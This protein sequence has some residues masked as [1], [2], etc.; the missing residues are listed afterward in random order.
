MITTEILRQNK[1]FDWSDIALRYDKP[2]LLLGNGFSLQFSENFSYNSLFNLFLENCDDTHKDLFSHFGTVNFEQI[3]RYLTYAKKVNELLALPSQPIDIALQNLKTGLIKTIETVHPRVENINFEQ[4]K[5]VAKQL[6]NFGDIFT[7][8]YDLF[9]YHI[10]MQSKDISREEKEYIAYQDY[11]WG[12]DCPL[13]FKQFMSTQGYVYKHLYYLHGS[14][15]IF[16]NKLEI[17]K[18]N[19]DN[20]ETELIDLISTQIQDNNFPIFI[21]EGT[22]LEKQM[23]INE[24]R[25]LTFCSDKLKVSSQPTVVFGNMLGDFDSHILKALIT[26]PKD[27]VYCIFIG[28]RSIADVNAEKYNFES[29]FNNYPNQIE[30]VDSSTVFKI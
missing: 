18:L 24:N 19:R 9:L 12:S 10:I 17:I 1:I 29:K 8:N 28:D 5:N 26:K 23:A 21:T 6:K 3:L 25:Y 16:K 7:T 14:L 30:F 22:G 13:G 4:L 20:D 2:N 15:F 11:Y 27:I